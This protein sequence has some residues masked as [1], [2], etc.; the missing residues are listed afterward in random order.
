[1]LHTFWLSNL[2][3]LQFRFSLFPLTSSSPRRRIEYLIAKWK[4]TFI[5]HD[6]GKL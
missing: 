6:N 1:M 2:P 4:L 5:I 3:F